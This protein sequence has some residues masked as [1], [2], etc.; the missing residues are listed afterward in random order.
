MIVMCI[1]S[2]MSLQVPLHSLV[3]NIQRSNKL[4]KNIKFPYISRLKILQNI[5]FSYLLVLILLASVLVLWGSVLIL[6]SGDVEVNPGPDS[7]EDTSFTSDDQSLASIETLSNHLSV[8]H[9]NIHSLVPKIDMD[10]SE[11]DANDVLAFSESWLNPNIS[12]DIIHIENVMP[13]IRTARV[14]RIGGGVVIYVRDCITCK[15]RADFEIRGVEAIWMQLNVKC[16]KNLSGEF[17]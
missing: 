16:K 9:L 13:P 3:L 14:N 17:L 4:Y 10:R 6:L 2:P 8:F 15:R 5:F 7:A 1:V 12:N 11:A